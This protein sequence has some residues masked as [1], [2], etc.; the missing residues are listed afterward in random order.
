MD[1]GDK[2]EQDAGDAAASPG[3]EKRGRGRPSKGEPVLVRLSAEERAFANSLGK[4]VAAEGV[5][6]ALNAVRHM[7]VDAV[8]ALSKLP[9][10]PLRALDTP[11]PTITDLPVLPPLIDLVTASPKV[12]TL[13]PRRQ[14]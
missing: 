1:D 13:R 9:P 14:P 10:A 8:L 7:G 5:R 2:S 4:G 3:S 12:A 6:M 11:L